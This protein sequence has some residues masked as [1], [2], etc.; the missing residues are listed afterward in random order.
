M[1]NNSLRT[2]TLE[3][4]PGLHLS[5]F[6]PFSCSVHGIVM[7]AALPGSPVAR[8]LAGSGQWGTLERNWGQEEGRSR[9]ISLLF[10]VPWIDYVLGESCKFHSPSSS[11]IGFSI[12]WGTPR[13]RLSSSVAFL[14]PSSWKVAVVSTA[15]ISRVPYHPPLSSCFLFSHGLLICVIKSPVLILGGPAAF[16]F[17]SQLIELL[18]EALVAQLVKNPPAMQETHVW[19]LGQEDPLGKEMATHSS[20]LP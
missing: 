1:C 9:H 12:Y 19:F 16:L 14:Y 18:R 17:R 6:P 8:L 11:C 20:I 10:S 13:S 2:F 15:L 3:S 7:M 5:L 4:V